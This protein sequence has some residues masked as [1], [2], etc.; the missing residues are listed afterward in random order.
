MLRKIQTSLWQS[1]RI[2]ILLIHTAITQQNETATWR[3]A[4][5]L[6]KRFAVLL[7]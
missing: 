2:D 5:K 7:L 1:C 4:Q 6:W 3:M